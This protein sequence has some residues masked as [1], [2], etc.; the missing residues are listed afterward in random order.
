MDTNIS[1]KSPMFVY[2]AETV[3]NPKSLKV[4]VPEAFFIDKDS[5]IS[6]TRIIKGGTNIFI[7]AT[8]PAI[9]GSAMKYNYITLPVIGSGIASISINGYTRSGPTGIGMISK[10]D[11]L[12]A[13]FVNNNPRYGI[14]IARG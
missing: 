13:E 2:A 12:I 14:I 10:G 7:N 9:S 5:D 11:R 8:V 4:F 1:F 3:T 6:E